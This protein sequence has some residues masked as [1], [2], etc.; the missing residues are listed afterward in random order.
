MV[1]IERGF[2]N[3]LLDRTVSEPGYNIQI[4]IS[5]HEKK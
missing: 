5:S 2:E 1:S 3:L 4:R